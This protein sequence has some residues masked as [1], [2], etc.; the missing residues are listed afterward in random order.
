M[1]GVT[2][3]Q[4]IPDPATTYVGPGASSRGPVTI[5]DAAVDTLASWLLSPWRTQPAVVVTV[6]DGNPWIDAKRIFRQFP[7]T[8]EVYVIANG[9][10]TRRL[11]AG[12]PCKFAV[13]G[14]AARIY[15]SG[16]SWTGA[17]T[18]APLLLCTSADRG[19]ETTERAIDSVH[20]TLHN[21]NTAADLHA[22]TPLPPADGLAHDVL[23]AAD[24]LDLAHH[25]ED[26]ERTTPLV[27]IS[28]HPNATEPYLPASQIANDLRDVAPVLVLS[29]AAT[30]G[31]TDGLGKR[32]LS[33]F[34]GAG[35]VYPPGVAWLNDMFAAPLHLCL[36]TREAGRVARNIV[37]DA[38]DVAHR[39]GI[40]NSPVAP[41]NTEVVDAKVEGPFD[42]HH[43]LIRTRRG[44]QA[45][46]RVEHLRVGIDR[47]RLL[48]KG[49]VL[50]GYVHGHGILPAFHPEPI[51]DDPLARAVA[52]YAD[53]AITLA[54]VETVSADAATVLLHPD[55]SLPLEWCQDEDLRHL[56]SPSE[57]I[58]VA[59]SFGS[60]R[61]LVRLADEIDPAELRPGMPVLPGGPPW[62]LPIDCIS[63]EPAPVDDSAPEPQPEEQPDLEPVPLLATAVPP[64]QAV[65]V[66]T[67]LPVPPNS[68]AEEL[69]E[70]RRALGVELRMANDAIDTLHAHLSVVERELRKRNDEVR[71]LRSRLRKRRVNRR[72]TNT[73]G[74]PAYLD[75]VRQLR[76]EIWLMYLSRVRED[77]RASIELPRNYTVGPDFLASIDQLEGV[78]R[79]KIMMVIVEVL[80]GQDKV[81]SAR[82]LHPWKI[83]KAGSQE[84]RP[85]G[86][87]AWRVSLQQ[88]TAG[89]RRLKYW[90]LRDGTRELDSVGHHDDGL[91]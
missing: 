10:L 73:G 41:A 6:V 80:T 60:D 61:L 82:A 55:L 33:V 1:N 20:R 67:D 34:F 54:R 50:R 38:L 31:L 87:K 22:R 89:A 49:Q 66:P 43:V 28:V 36:S 29:A 75:P 47:D 48:A 3:T 84:S 25:L 37:N 27:V 53:G 39:A 65:P 9:A 79:E 46:L 24:A 30:Y 44:G 35:R 81:S 7:D 14:G 56:L 74:D 26:P 4:R 57:V 90:V 58:E 17:L 83:G 42:A 5:T 52:S 69:R 86:A 11:E 16:T 76:H 32:E 85:D 2:M 64:A 77:Q 91:R 88:G 78:S 8:A 15:P 59:I 71:D 62:L 51:S 12:L 72:S 40:L 70:Q 63:G 45:A 13:Y 19:E 18:A 23:T 68:G 21:T